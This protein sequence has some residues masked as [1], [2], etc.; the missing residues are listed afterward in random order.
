[1]LNLRVHLVAHASRTLARSLTIV[2]RYS[3]VRLQGFTD[4]NSVN[5]EIQILDYPTHQGGLMPQLAYAFALHFVG[6]DLRRTL[7]HYINQ[8]DRSLLSDIHATSSGIKV[9]VFH[10]Q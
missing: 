8:P 3:A 1:M 10:L 4:R 9:V 2:I 7:D 5:S 6:K